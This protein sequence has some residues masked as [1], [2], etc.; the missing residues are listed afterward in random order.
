[1]RIIEA[2]K[3]ILAWVGAIAAVIAFSA[4]VVVGMACAP[5]NVAW[6]E[7]TGGG[8]ACPLF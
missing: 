3:V 7:A 5:W 8:P 6:H 4:F 1:M 2:A